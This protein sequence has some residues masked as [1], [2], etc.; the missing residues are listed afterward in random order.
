[1]QSKWRLLGV[2][3]SA[4]FGPEQ[5]QLWLRASAAAVQMAKA[6]LVEDKQSGKHDLGGFRRVHVNDFQKIL[7]QKIS[8][9][10]FL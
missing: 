3:Q 4:H 6:G 2:K 5:I 1:L 7:H 10:R 8:Y 9:L